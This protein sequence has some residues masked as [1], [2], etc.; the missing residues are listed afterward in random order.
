[1]SFTNK[2]LHIFHSVLASRLR[3]HLCNVTKA[4]GGPRRWGRG[5]IEAGARDGSGGCF[6]FFPWRGLG[7]A[8]DGIGGK[9]GP[10]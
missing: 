8:G 2:M 9:R 6:F 5:E 4:P 3:A 10:L 1:M 7:R